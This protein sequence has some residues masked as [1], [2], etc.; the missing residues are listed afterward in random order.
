MIEQK[1]ILIDQKR[2]CAIINYNRD[3]NYRLGIIFFPGLSQSKAGTYNLF[4]QICS[5]LNSDIPT[6]RFDYYGYGDSEGE[7]YEVD[8]DSMINNAKQ[9]TNWFSKKI[10]CNRFIYIGHGIGNYVATVLA[11][12][13]PLVEA[14]LIM[15]HMNALI[16]DSK[17][18][19][20]IKKLIESEDIVDTGTFAVWDK[21]MDDFFAIL[22]GRMNRSKGIV[23]KK[24]FLLQLIEF[25]IEKYWE[26]CSNLYVLSQNNEKMI[27]NDS[28]V[29]ND[30]QIN[31]ILLLDMLEREK[32]I[33]RICDWCVSREDDA[34]KIWMEV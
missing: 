27:C 6:L 29:I 12:N 31:D 2:L 18:D 10:L 34:K 23:L 25:N 7:S 11:E 13:N 19:Q 9:I 24:R 5:S 15:P 4:S 14:L 22:G 1:W 17:Y 3:K 32:A 16:N 28:S 8:L 26:K 30:F 33:K 20:I 21:N